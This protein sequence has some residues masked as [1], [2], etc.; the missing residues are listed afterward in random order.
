[1][2]W[3]GALERTITAMHGAAG[4]ARL[5]DLSRRVADYERR[6]DLR[7]L[8]PFG[9][10]S[11]NYV[12]PAS[13]LDGWTCVLKLCYGGPEVDAEMAALRMADGDGMVRLIEEDS[14]GNA[15]L[16]ERAVPGDMLVDEPD[17]EKATR[18]AAGVMAALW[19]PVPAGHGFPTV[20]GWGRGFERMRRRF[21]VGTGPLP[22]ELTG[23]AEQLYAELVATS[24]EP[25]VLHGDLHHYNILRHQDRWLAIDPNGVVGEPAFEIGALMRNRLP[26]F[27]DDSAATD[28]LTGRIRIVANAAGLDADRMRQWTIARALLSVW[29]LIEDGGESTLSEPFARGVFRT[30]E[31]LERVAL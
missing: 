9:D 24:A 15:M 26:T 14:T 7:M 20:E 4:R 10:L 28:V 1:M 5:D 17:N 22:A 13:R 6:W 16:L 12:A 11:F 30:A 2:A 25:V 29:W 23:R 21:D 3:P 27:D 19:R 18:I 8:P 31:L